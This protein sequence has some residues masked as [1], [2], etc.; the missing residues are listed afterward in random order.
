MVEQPVIEPLQS[1]V[2]RLKRVGALGRSPAYVKLL[3]YLAETTI[4]GSPCSELSIAFEVFNKDENFD[5]ASD[6]T[7]RVYIYNLRRKLDVYYS[8]PGS[9]DEI[10]LIVPKGEYRLLV[11]R[12][13]PVSKLI[14]L[15]E[16]WGQNIHSIGLASVGLVVGA[17]LTFLLMVEA[18]SKHQ[19]SDEQLAFWGDILTDDRPVLVVVGDYYIFGETGENGETR[20]VREFDINS[21]SDL[22]GKLKAQTRGVGAGSID[23]HFDLA[24]TY[25]PR[26]SVYALASVQKILQLAEKTP[27]ITMM[28]EF[29]AEDLR[30]NH[31]IYLGYISGLGVLERYTFSASRFD[32]GYSYDDLADAV[33]GEHYSSNFIAA[34]GDRNFVDYGLIASFSVAENNQ[35]VILTGTRD[36]GLME[37]SELAITPDVLS[38][39]EL[40]VNETSAFL[41]VFKV[42][43]FNLTN[44]SGELINSEYL[45]VDRI[46]GQ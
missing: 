4:A 15:K 39:M 26:G 33:T 30:A 45:D 25:L 46:S 2:E 14:N 20:L 37:M 18:D 7:V 36:A 16:S 9:V 27:R 40:S 23:K 41:S 1:A 17:M 11:E 38:K 8:G 43:G 5:V 35:V 24:L 22:R 19:F 6:S 3:D 28:S 10:K 21:E 44:I 34:E 31:V 32:I 12:V 13:K 29:S 42:N